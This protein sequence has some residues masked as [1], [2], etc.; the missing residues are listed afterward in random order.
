MTVTIDRLP[1]FVK[2]GTI[3]PVSDV[4]EY[5]DAQKGKPVTALVF[6]GTDASFMLYNDDGIS[7]DYKKGHYQLTRL[8][9]NDKQSKLTVKGP[10]KVAW[11]IVK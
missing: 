5:S 6:P 2:A 1:L 8:V 10:E 3:I 7:Y 11:R 4:V 9:W